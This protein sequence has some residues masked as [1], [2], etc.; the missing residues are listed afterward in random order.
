MYNNVRKESLDLENAIK[1]DKIDSRIKLES[2]YYM[3]NEMFTKVRLS[4]ES[5][6]EKNRVLENTKKSQKNMLKE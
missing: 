6:N 5:D 2:I 3:T 1:K 4:S